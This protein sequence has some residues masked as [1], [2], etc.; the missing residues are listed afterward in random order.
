MQFITCL[1]S[2]PSTTGNCLM[3]D[4]Y[5]AHWNTG[6]QFCMHACAY[7]APK[8]NEKSCYKCNVCPW[9]IKGNAILPVLQLLNVSMHVRTRKY[10]CVL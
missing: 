9:A 3:S 8:I 6:S 2:I 7:I 5:F 10:T 4:C 1:E